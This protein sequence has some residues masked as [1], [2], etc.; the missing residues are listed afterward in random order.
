[1]KIK[2]DEGPIRPWG[3]YEILLDEEY[4]KVKKIV[5]GPERRLSY[6]YHYKRK[7]AWTVVQGV[8]T[9]TINGETKDYHPG[10]TILIDFM[11][12]HRMAN[13]SKIENMILIEVQTGSYFGEDDIVRIEDDFDR[14][15]E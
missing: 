12:Q 9:V 5:V 10:E 1:M 15:I 2:K 7:E 14:E 13:K 11:D 6:Q 8:A 4:C 3:N